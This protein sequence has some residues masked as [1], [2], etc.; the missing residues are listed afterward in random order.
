[1]LHRVCVSDN[2][3]VAGIIEAKSVTI[4]LQQIAMAI[5]I[6]DLC[7]KNYIRYLSW[8]PREEKLFFILYIY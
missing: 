6:F 1:M 2:I 7:L 5:D 3:N 4:I 8:I